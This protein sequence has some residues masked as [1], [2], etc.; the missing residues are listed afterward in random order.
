MGGRI[1]REEIPATL[2]VVSEILNEVGISTERPIAECLLGSTGKKPSAGDI[3]VGVRPFEPIAVAALRKHES[4]LNVSRAGAITSIVVAIQGLSQVDR[5]NDRNGLVQVDLIPGDLTWLKQFFFADERSAFKGAHRNL[6][7]SS[8]LF[9]FRTETK[10]PGWTVFERSEGPM[11][12]QNHGL[13]DRRLVRKADKNGK[14]YA[15]KFD[16]EIFNK[17]YN[18]EQAA[19]HYFGNYYRDAFTSVETLYRAIEENY[20]R[21]FASA[22]YSR[23]FK[24]YLPVHLNIDAYP[25]RIVP[26]MQKERE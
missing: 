15:T 9:G 7:I 5:G 10:K 3:D 12:S 18:L 17:Q 2:V 25:W 4:V 20:D 23:Y 24:D 22:V 8:Y 11:F 21:E 1:L 6:L 16:E 14:P 19:E 26:N 13:C